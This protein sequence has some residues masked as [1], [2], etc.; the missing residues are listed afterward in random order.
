MWAFAVVAR[1]S[2]IFLHYVI[3]VNSTQF[4]S[5]NNCHTWNK[6]IA[7]LR[8]I[9]N[10]VKTRIALLRQV[11]NKN[12]ILFALLRFA[13]L[14]YLFVLLHTYLFRFKAKVKSSHARKTTT[15]SVYDS[16]CVSANVGLKR[17][18]GDGRVTVCE[19]C[20]VFSVNTT[21]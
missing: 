6:G 15:I 9:D 5:A 18:I 19:S 3:H 10:K 14:H 1:L 8:K 4:S 20:A 16:V 2:R 17:N 7:L 21:T 12:A 11:E 13:S